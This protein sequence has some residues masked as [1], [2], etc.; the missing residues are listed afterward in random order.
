MMM[1]FLINSQLSCLHVQR[2]ILFVNSKSSW[3]YHVL[4]NVNISK[5]WVLFETSLL[6]A[7]YTQR[8]WEEKLV[9]KSII[10]IFFYSQTLKL[11]DHILSQ[12]FIELFRSAYFLPLSDRMISHKLW[13]SLVGTVCGNHLYDG[14]LSLLVKLTVFSCR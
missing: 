11:R 8:R 7:L 1:M 4:F 5:K 2:L 14:K 13:S 3:V 6:S 12:T 9:M 10:M